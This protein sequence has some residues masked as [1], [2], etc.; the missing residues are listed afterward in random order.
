MKA[1]TADMI[2]N[3]PAIEAFPVWVKSLLAKLAVGKPPALLLVPK[4][5][6]LLRKRGIQV[7]FLS[8]ETT[9]DMAL[10]A[11]AGATGFISDRPSFVAAYLKKNPVRLHRADDW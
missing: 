8:V 2:H 4:M 6:T 5:F 11:Q 10:A 9:E 3:E 7:L 1:I